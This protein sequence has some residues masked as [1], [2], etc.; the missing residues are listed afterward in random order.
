MA[1][2]ALSTCGVAWFLRITL[3]VPRQAVTACKFRGRSGT[4]WEC[5]SSYTLHLVLHV[6]HSTLYTLHFTLH[7]LHSTVHSPHFTLYTLHSTLYTRHS[8]L[9]TLRSTL[10]TLYSLNPTPYSL[11]STLCIVCTP[12]STLHTPHSA[13]RPIPHSAYNGMV[14]RENG[15]RICKTFVLTCFEKVFYVM[16]L[17]VSCRFLVGH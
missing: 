2:A 3:A 13:T 8:T 6:L 9:Y 14:T 1:G 11:H 16:C 17:Q 5:N 12:H 7:T 10:H 15:G 4:W